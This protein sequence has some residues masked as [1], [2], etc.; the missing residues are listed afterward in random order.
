MIGREERERGGVREGGEKE[1][2]RRGGVGRKE[3]DDTR[4]EDKEDR[5]EWST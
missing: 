5:A 4:D 3:G 2:E 1:R